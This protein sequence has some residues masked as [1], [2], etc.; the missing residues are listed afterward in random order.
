MIFAT[1]RVSM[2]SQACSSTTTFMRLRFC[3]LPCSSLKCSP[4]ACAGQK[5]GHR[6]HEP[7]RGPG[8]LTCLLMSLPKREHVHESVQ[9]PAIHHSEIPMQHDLKFGDDDRAHASSVHMAW[10]AHDICWRQ[11]EG[12][13]T[14]FGATAQ[15][16]NMPIPALC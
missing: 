8:S 12:M 15:P 10:A 4:S 9:G 14:F 7:Q 11:H 3:P 5:M 2:P 13:Q 16:G 1:S 6:I